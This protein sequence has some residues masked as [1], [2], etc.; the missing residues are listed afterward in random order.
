LEDFAHPFELLQN[1]NS[2]FYYLVNSL[3]QE[4]RVELIEIAQK[5]HEDLEKSKNSTPLLT[6]LPSFSV[7]E[8]QDDNDSE[9]RLL[10]SVPK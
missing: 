7:N 5:A 8:S 2:V 10:L 6:N 9:T 3:E 4:E 1:K